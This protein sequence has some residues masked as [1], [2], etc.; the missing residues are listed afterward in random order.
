MIIFNARRWS[1]ASYEIT[2]VRLSVNLSLSFFKIGSLVFSD[3]AH[4]DS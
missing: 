4:V 1:T 3:I 2:P